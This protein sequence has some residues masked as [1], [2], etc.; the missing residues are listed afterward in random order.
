MASSSV[1]EEERIY[2]GTII[3]MLNRLCTMRRNIRRAELKCH[4]SWPNSR[5]RLFVS[6]MKLLFNSWRKMNITILDI[7]HC[8]AF[9]LKQY[10]SESEHSSFSRT[11]LRNSTRRP[12]QNLVSET[13][14][15][16]KKKQESGCPELCCV[17]CCICI[18]NNC[19]I[20]INIPWQETY[21][22]H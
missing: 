3:L 8:H 19:D 22:S 1:V 6:Y 14:Y 15:F 7:I 4:F 10:V 12:R 17:L 9:Y 18:Y 2:K 20:Y 13:S 21:R 5:W 16:N 11:H